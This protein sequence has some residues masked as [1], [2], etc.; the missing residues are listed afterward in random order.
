MMAQ[1]GRL[2]ISD[3]KNSSNL[4]ATLLIS[5]MRNKNVDTTIQFSSATLVA[6]TMSLS[7][8]AAVGWVA[9]TLG[10]VM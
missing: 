7:H 6:L 4:I 3:D 8:Q 2:T 9:L 1:G 10:G 5:Q